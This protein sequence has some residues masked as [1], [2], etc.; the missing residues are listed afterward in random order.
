MLDPQ[1]DSS[2]FMI[3]SVSIMLQSIGE[4][5]INSDI[6][7]SEILEAQLAATVLDEAKREV[8]AEGW[9]FNVDTNYIL[10]PDANG[11][12]SIP[13]NVLDISSNDADIVMR[14]WRLYSKKN[15]S[16]VFEESLKMN[17]I[18]NM[19]F[20]SL[21]HPLRTYI[22][23]MATVKFQ[24]RTVMDTNVFSYTEKDTDAAFIIA[25]RSGLYR[26]LFYAV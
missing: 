21:T 17:I 22:T 8:L 25:R 15:Q 2:K 24:A 19:D 7:M 10:P 3:Q 16:A 1:Y 26:T 4:M 23:M 18:W 14:D 13:A 20:N 12:I 6:E 5:P 9:N 11:Y